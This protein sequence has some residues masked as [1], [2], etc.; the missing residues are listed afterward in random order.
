MSL[1]E[2]L[3]TKVSRIFNTDS[4]EKA[5]HLVRSRRGMAVLALISFVESSLPLPILTDPFLAAT[6]LLNRAQAARLVILTTFA[7]A[8]GGLLAYFLAIYF[9][10]LILDWMTPGMAAEFHSM[11]SASQSSTFVLTILG[12]VTPV[13]YT[14]VAWVVAVLEGSVAVFFAASVLGRGLRYSI[15]GYGTWRFGPQALAYSKRYLG[16]AT[17]VVVILALLFLWY[18]M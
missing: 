5:E 1:E 7:S 4:I 6:V 9:F 14:L 2:K 17:L 3:E 16:R 11:V 10:D 12:A 18:K 8:L 13:P 15:V